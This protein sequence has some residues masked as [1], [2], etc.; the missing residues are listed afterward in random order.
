MIHSPVYPTV[1]PARPL[2]ASIPWQSLQSVPLVA[3]AAVPVA[4][5]S[6][7]R[8][9]QSMQQP[10]TQSTMA[11]VA[12]PA[13]TS[14]VPASLKPGLS[15]QMREYFKEQLCYQNGDTA[16]KLVWVMVRDERG[17]YHVLSRTVRQ[18]G[19]D[20]VMTAD[21]VDTASQSTQRVGSCQQLALS[22]V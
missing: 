5:P 6:A 9:W 7:F 2:T 15:G 3:V 4:R 13:V 19:G 17:E 11:S 22:H 20:T 1:I 10:S 21:P 16:K 12:L 8:P 18:G 14:S